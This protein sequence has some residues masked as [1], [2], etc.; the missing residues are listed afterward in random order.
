MH[1]DKTNGHKTMETKYMAKIAYISS[2]IYE[3]K[4][5]QVRNPKSST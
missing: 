1:S 3:M 5:A 2:P 4:G